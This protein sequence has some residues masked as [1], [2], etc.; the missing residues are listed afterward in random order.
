MLVSGTGGTGPGRLDVNAGIVGG[1]GT[2]A[3]ALSINNGGAVSPGTSVGQLTVNGQT[4]FAAGGSYLFEYASVD[5]ANLVNG[6]THDHLNGVG[7]GASLNVTATNVG[8][9]RFT[10]NI[11][12]QTFSP[13]PTATNYVIGTFAGGIVGFAPDKFQFTGTGFS[14]LPTI[15]TQGNNLVLTLVPVPEPVHLLVLCATAL[16]VHCVRRRRAA[17]A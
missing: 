16:G 7:A 4:T 1:T 6:V 8:A 13:T 10:I 9:S 5:Q 11:T 3:G 12:A 15:A 17:A 2:I 14:G